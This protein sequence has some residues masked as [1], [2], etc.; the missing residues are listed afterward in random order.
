MAIWA[1]ICGQSGY[2][3]HATLGARQCGYIAPAVSVV[4]TPEKNQRA[5]KPMPSIKC[6]T[7]RQHQS[8]YLS[9]TNLRGRV[10]KVAKWPNGPCHVGVHKAGTKVKWL[11]HL[12][13]L[14]GALRW[15]EIATPTYPVALW[16]PCVGKAATKP[17]PSWRSQKGGGIQSG[18]KKRALFGANVSA[19]WLHATYHRLVGPCVG[20]VAR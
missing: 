12:C 20:K 10:G 16:G 18:Y 5:T 13:H 17:L 9:H 14:G 6:P 1:P 11:H 4:D 7:S 8:G 3:T 19:N 15:E 2:V